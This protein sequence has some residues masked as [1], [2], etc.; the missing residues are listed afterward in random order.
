MRLAYLTTQYPKVSHTF[1]R[2]ELQEM[3]RRG[4]HVLRLA[5]R[6][7]TTP[8]VDPEDEAELAKTV[9]CLAASPVLL[10]VNQI[11]T[12]CTHPIASFRALMMTL[13]MGLRSERGVLR[14]LAYLVEAN[15]F[16]QVLRRDKIE[17]VHVHFGTNATTVAR[18]ISCLGGPSYSFTIHGPAEFD[19]PRGLDLQSKQEDAA[20][21]VAIS[22]Y[23][24]GQLRRWVD[25]AH[26]KRIHV[27]RCG[28]S[29]DFLTPPA[30]IDKDSRV[31]VC[32]GRLC[33]QKG[34][35]LLID[36]F[37]PVAK[38]Q[39]SARLVLAGDGPMRPAIE[40]RIEELGLQ[41]RVDI[42]GW[43]TE[44]Q[45]R[46]QLIGARAL[47]LPSFAEGL[48]VV[49]MEA[50]ALGRPVIATYVAGIPEL[51]VHKRTGWLVP[52]GHSRAL[53]KAMRQAL[54]SPIETLHT[55]GKRGR[56]RV[57]KLHD[58]RREAAKLEKLFMRY[59]YHGQPQADRIHPVTG[60]HSPIPV[61]LQS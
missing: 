18:L 43:L 51:L 5:I 32:V 59:A 16:F 58:V 57:L 25:V 36:A 8:P 54:T 38:V 35:L 3:E 1:I 37:A 2:R 20:F 21:T 23:C 9:H 47:V 49:I 39:P 4:H 61:A 19:A 48:P 55:M 44:S 12:F 10:V 22:H 15:F 24:S 31:L 13:R 53:T 7:P 41:D 42:T 34:Q 50:M 40:R 33:E 60:R 17:H 14:H 26:W 45:V 6:R 52:A 27:V 29:D 56:Q 46:D 11:R 28:V 30:P